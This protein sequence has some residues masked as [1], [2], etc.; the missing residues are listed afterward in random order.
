M[1]K[2]D[3]QEQSRN[4][5]WS[6]DEYA[7]Q[8]DEERPFNHE[9]HSIPLIE[10]QRPD[11][12]LKTLVEKSLKISVI[13]VISSIWPYHAGVAGTAQEKD[14]STLRQRLRKRRFSVSYSCPRGQHALSVRLY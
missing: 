7:M 12:C 6:A 14:V 9:G 11:P 13:V 1:G 5:M 8:E 10:H 2:G 4:S 3:G